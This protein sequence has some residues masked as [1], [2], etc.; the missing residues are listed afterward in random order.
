M[1]WIELNPENN[2][3]PARSAVGNDFVR[4]HVGGGWDLTVLEGNKTTKYRYIQQT[5]QFDIYTNSG[6]TTTKITINDKDGNNGEINAVLY[7]L[8]KGTKNEVTVKISYSYQVNERQS[9]EEEWGDDWSTQTSSAW[10]NEGSLDV[11][12][13]ND[14]MPSDFWGNPQPGE[15][16][17]EHITQSNVNAWFDQF[18]V[19][20]S[21][22]EQYSY[23]NYFDEWR[24]P[25]GDIGAGWYNELSEECGG[26]Y[27][28]SQFD[29][30]IS[31]KHFQD[32]A[33]KVTDWS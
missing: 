28:V 1:A 22:K 6:K 25:E 12:T 27:R 11:Y 29:E 4:L 20:K 9:E 33:Q 19:W 30:Y 2:Q 24:D 5:Y 31:A 13:R 26:S 8:T 10:K 7:G 18:G 15:Y 3:M 17:D 23:Y 14:K 32:L 21:W 16:I